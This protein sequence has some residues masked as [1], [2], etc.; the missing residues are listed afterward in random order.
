LLRECKTHGLL[1][2]VLGEE[3]KEKLLD[4]SWPGNVTEL[5]QAMGRLSDV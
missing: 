5:R 3:I 2:K 1:P 4:Y